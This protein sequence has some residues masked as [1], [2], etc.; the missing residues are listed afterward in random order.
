MSGCSSVV[1]HNLAKVGVEG[2]NPFAR[3]KFSKDHSTLTDCPGSSPCS[4]VCSGSTGAARS[5]SLIFSLFGILVCF[6][7]LAGCQTNEEYQARLNAD[8]DARLSAFNGATIADFIAR[9][10]MVPSS[11]YAVAD[12]RVFVFQTAPVFITLPATN[13]T[14]AVTRSA[15]CQLLVQTVPNGS[16]GTADNWKIVG[17]QRSGGCNN[18]PI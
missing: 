16:G 13:I 10:G 14:P 9:T 1:E 4:A 17:T 5:V 2:S 11:A 6:V 3:S 7:L 8:L 18:L 12:G 15:Q